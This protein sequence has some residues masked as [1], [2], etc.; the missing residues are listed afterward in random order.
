MRDTRIA[1]VQFEH[2]DG[3]KQYNLGRVRELAKVA[4]SRGA[5]LV[6]FHECCVIWQG[7]HLCRQ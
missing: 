4:V 3:D 2:R 5:E 7:I 6:S 1:T